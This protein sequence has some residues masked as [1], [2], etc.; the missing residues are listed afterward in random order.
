MLVWFVVVVPPPPVVTLPLVVPPALVVAPPLVV[1][2]ALVVAGALGAAA[3]GVGWTRQ[4]V[5]GT[6]PPR[7]RPAQT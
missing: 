3:V 5:T 2:P 1:V 7:L 4:A 6:V